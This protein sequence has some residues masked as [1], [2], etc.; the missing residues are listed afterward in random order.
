[1]IE[2]EE[3]LEEKF[4]EYSLVDEQRKSLLL[5][6]GLVKKKDDE[7]WEHSVR[8]GLKCGDIAE[9]THII[10]PKGLFYPGLLHDVGKA[11][12]NSDSLKKKTGFG[13]KDMRE[14]RKHVFYG[15]NLLKGI[16]E[17]SAEVLLLH[18]YF[19]ENSRGYPKRLPRRFH[20]FSKGTR[21][22]IVYCGRLLSIADFHDAAKY[23]KNDKFTPG[24]TSGLDQ[25][26]VKQALLEFNPD[27]SYLIEE[28]YNKGIF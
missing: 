22:L 9:F 5:Y 24:M 3:R 26:G 28:L 10:E 7:I 19:Q 23:R 21:A 20:G 13:P 8:V 11:M 15:Y 12:V 17:F 14:L 4:H 6:L 27:Q 2:L 1:M 18:H 25:D 16:H